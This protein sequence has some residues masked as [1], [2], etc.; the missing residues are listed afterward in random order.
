MDCFYCAKPCYSSTPTILNVCQCENTVHVNC[1]AEILEKAKICGIC[2]SP[3]KYRLES[4]LVFSFESVANT[5]IYCATWACN[6]F[7]ALFVTIFFLAPEYFLEKYAGMQF[8]FSAAWRQLPSKNIS[9]L[10]FPGGDYNAEFFYV[11]HGLVLVLFVI[12]KYVV[13]LF[14]NY[15][16]QQIVSFLKR[17]EDSWATMNMMAMSIGTVLIAHAFGNFHYFF[18]C[19]IGTIENKDFC[20]L[21][22][23]WASLFSSAA[24]IILFAFCMGLAYLAT[25][26]CKA[27][28]ERCFIMKRH[29]ILISAEKTK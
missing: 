1:F 11:F 28:Y 10:L 14:E 12:I 27:I 18:Y 4:E 8:T 6:F 21:K 24:G 7:T 22:M 16:I 19:F 5:I 9:L 23:N 2:N 25:L 20:Q 15:G 26:I 17:F 29:F 3:Y 13:Y